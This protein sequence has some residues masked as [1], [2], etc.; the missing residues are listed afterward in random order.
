MKGSWNV[1]DQGKV[2]CHFFF[3]PLLLISSHQPPLPPHSHNYQHLVATSLSEATRAGKRLRELVLRSSADLKCVNLMC[4]KVG[5]PCICRLARVLS[6]TPDLERLDLA[7]NGLT[8]LPEEVFKLRNL[9]DLDISHNQL[10]ELPSSVLQLSH[11]RALDVQGNPL[12]EEEEEG[13]Q[14]A[15]TFVRVRQFI[16]ERIPT[17]SA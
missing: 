15:Q 14:E 3:L 10:T 13:K 2:A 4:E 8:A 17:G 1:D 16:R 11:L 5:E 9:R 7:K 6:L 12:R